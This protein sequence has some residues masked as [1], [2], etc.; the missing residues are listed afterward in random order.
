MT[1][2]TQAQTP[3]PASP[4]D[5]ALVSRA[6]RGDRGAMVGLYRRYVHEMFGFAC[7]QLGSIQDAEDVTSEVFL[8]VVNAI[9]T[10]RGQ[11]SFRTWLYAIAHRQIAD[12][13]RRNGHH[14]RAVALDPSRAAAPEVPAVA[15]PRAT[16]LGHAVLSRLPENYRR[17]LELRVMGE[18]SIRDTA[19]ELGL[20][21]ANVKVLQHRALKRAAQIA[22][23][24]SRGNDDET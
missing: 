4:E 17:V 18:R 21:E 10:Y 2:V 16:A 11:S 20:T 5:D 3:N 24:L 22:D 14:A 9:D 6:Q 15:N 8:R 1:R 12:H 19:G 7:N 23:T 13:W